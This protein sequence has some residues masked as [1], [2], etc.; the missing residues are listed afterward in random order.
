MR[1]PFFLLAHGWAG[2]PGLWDGLVAELHRAGVAGDDVVHLDQGYFGPPADPVLPTGRPIIG[3]GHSLGVALLLERGGLAGLVALNGFTR[4][5]AADDLPVGVPPRILAQMQRRFTAEPDKV[6]GD[7]LQRAGLP[8]PAGRP[9]P[10]RL[11]AGLALLAAMDVRDVPLPTAFNALAGADDPIVTPSHARACF[12][13]GLSVTDGG[14]ALPVTAPA[15]C[16][17]LALEVAASC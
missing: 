12:P 4:F 1:K 3:I 14:H 5:T 6:L 11:A 9:D 15:L 2:A 8:M 7:F 17:A 13:A 16:A 10:D